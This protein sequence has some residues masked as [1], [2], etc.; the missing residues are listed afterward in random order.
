[1][2]QTNKLKG[3]RQTAILFASI[4]CTTLALAIA[5]PALAIDAHA[6]Q[7]AKVADHPLP[8]AVPAVPAQE[9][10]EPASD[11][12]VDQQLKSADLKPGDFLWRDDAANATGP[13]RL[14]VSLSEQRAYLYR[15]ETL[16]AVS[17]VSTGRTGHPTPTGTFPITEKRA[18]HFSNKYDNAPMPHMQRLTN[19][20]IALH[21]G[22]IPGRPASHG[23]VR[24][25][26]KFAA[27]L[28]KVTRRGTPVTI[29]S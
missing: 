5:T 17:T 6:V 1:M 9:S 2:N 16:V 10:G 7:E 8:S 29:T 21:A 19:D 13:V 14:V 15:G 23:C 4:C 28:F 20:G 18:V 22:Q 24:L 27:A 26:S 25:P 11:D 12:S 3:M